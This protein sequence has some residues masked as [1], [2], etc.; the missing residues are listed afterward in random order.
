M[1]FP[2]LL[3][4]QGT[5]STQQFLQAHPPAPPFSAP[6]TSP[7]TPTLQL[8]LSPTAPIKQF[9][10]SPRNSQF[11]R[12]LNL[13]LK[14]HPTPIR[15]LPPHLRN[16]RLPRQHRARKPNLDILHHPKCLHD[17]FPA[18]PEEAQA[19]QDGSFETAYLAEFRVDVEG[20]A[21]AIQA[22]EGSLVVG[23]FSSTTASGARLGAG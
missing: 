7:N 13:S 1:L 12:L 16:K 5:N 8:R 18:E 11:P 4:Y 9:R 23:G 21:V 14:H 17:M 3:H 19:M 20:V 6:W 22:V 2:N 15:S 10:R